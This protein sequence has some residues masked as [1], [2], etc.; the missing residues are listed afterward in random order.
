MAQRIEETKLQRK[1]LPFFSIFW[2]ILCVTVLSSLV[3]DYAMFLAFLELSKN[4]I[5]IR[6]ET[7]FLMSQFLHFVSEMGGVYFKYFAL[8]M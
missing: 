3:G 1:M 6:Q 8:F 7:L 5:R 2:S 4:A